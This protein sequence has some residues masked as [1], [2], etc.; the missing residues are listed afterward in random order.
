[1]FKRICAGFVVLVLVFGMVACG[2]GEPS[3]S[4]ANPGSGGSSASDEVTPAPDNSQADAKYVVTIDDCSRTVVNEYTGDKDV[5]VIT[6][7]FT[8]NSNEETS[9]LYAILVNAFQNGD[10]LLSAIELNAEFMDA[11]KS[12]IAPGATITVQQAFI[13]NDD[14]P[15]LVE[16][17]DL[18]RPGS[19]LY[20]SREFLLS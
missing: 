12:E 4:S 1:M 9:F 8:N 14:S 19:S 6:F 16:C 17:D 11:M 5:V 7:T 10:T 18:Y 13:I 3:G 15:V 2:G 20:A